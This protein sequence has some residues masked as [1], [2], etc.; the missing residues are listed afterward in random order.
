MSNDNPNINTS[1]SQRLEVRRHLEMGGTLTADQAKE[2]FGCARLASRIGELRN[3]GMPIEMRWLRVTNRYG[4]QVRIG[5][6]YLAAND[7]AQEGVA[8]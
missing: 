8:A 7:A 5:E 1:I 2:L 3:A 4:K 6:Y